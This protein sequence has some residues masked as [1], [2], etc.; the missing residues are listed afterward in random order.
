MCTAVIGFSIWDKQDIVEW[1][2]PHIQLLE[3]SYLLEVCVCATD[4][5]SRCSP[6]LVSGV[7][8]N[9]TVAKHCG[10]LPDQ[11]THRGKQAVDSGVTLDFF[12]LNLIWDATHTHT[13]VYIWASPAIGERMR[14]ICLTY[15]SLFFSCLISRIKWMYSWCWH[16]QLSELLKSRSVLIWISAD[17]SWAVVLWSHHLGAALLNVSGSLGPEAWTRWTQTPPRHQRINKQGGT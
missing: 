16:E 8:H 3:K 11:H 5:E 15:K 9:V 12:F 13:S 14:K 7:H 10:F 6:V 4:Q 17:G 2:L 1:D